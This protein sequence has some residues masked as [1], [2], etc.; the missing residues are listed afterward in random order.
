MGIK[1]EDAPDILE[2]VRDLRDTMGMF[3]IQMDNISVM[4][5]HGSSSRGTVARCHALGK[6]MQKALGRER[7][8]FYVLEFISERFDKLAED[9][10]TKT[11]IHE[12]LH[13]PKSFGGGFKHHDFVNHRNINQFFQ[14]YKRL[15]TQK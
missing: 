6:I 5:S 13:I 15:K 9:D 11:I 10:K 12:L 14:E 3:H 1:Y 2:I 7:R 8:G 4:R